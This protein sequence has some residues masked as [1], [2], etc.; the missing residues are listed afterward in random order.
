MVLQFFNDL[1]SLTIRHIKYGVKAD[2]AR[3][4]GLTILNGIHIVLQD[5]YDSD[6]NSMQNSIAYALLVSRLSTP[7][8]KPDLL[9]LLRFTDG[10]K[11]AWGRLWIRVSSCVTRSLNVGSN[12]VIVSLVQVGVGFLFCDAANFIVR[13]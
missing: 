13:T 3:A 8:T 5:R 10:C 6:R 12:L 4:F 2:Y 7:S 11:K 9:F 1:K